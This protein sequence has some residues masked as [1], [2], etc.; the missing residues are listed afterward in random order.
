MTRVL[1]PALVGLFALLFGLA[2]AQ[3]SSYLTPADRS[4]I[5][6]KAISR[7]SAPKC[8]KG[9]YYATQALKSSGASVESCNCKDLQGLLSDS[10][11]ALDLY[12]AKSVAGDCNCELK[13]PQDAV[14]IARRDLQVAVLCAHCVIM[15]I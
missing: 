9:T 10:G 2:H 15:V 7:L 3:L 12:Y 4:A 14:D 5:R 11:S 13:Y 6:E 8:L 1:A